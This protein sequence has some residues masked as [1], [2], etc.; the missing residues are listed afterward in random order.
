[1]VGNARQTVIMSPEEHI[2]S[3]STGLLG[4]RGC[5]LVAHQGTARTVI[6]GFDWCVCIFRGSLR[7]NP[8]RRS[9]CIFRDSLRMNPSRKKLVRQKDSRNY[10]V[11]ACTTKQ[12][13]IMIG[14]CYAR[15]VA[16]ELDDDNKR[17]SV[18][19]LQ[20]EENRL[21]QVPNTLQRQHQ[22]ELCALFL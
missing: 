16:R 6:A 7:M 1:M 20:N 12:N 2:P 3:T 19:S 14:S 13:I 15:G 9:V 10:C 4:R 8:S 5:D 17:Q 11:S 21:Q 22:S 18:D